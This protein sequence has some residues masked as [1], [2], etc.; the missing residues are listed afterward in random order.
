MGRWPPS[1]LP[2]FVPAD[3]GDVGGVRVRLWWWCG[4][5]WRG[6]VSPLFFSNHAPHLP[7]HDR[8]PLANFLKNADSASM[9][10]HTQNALGQHI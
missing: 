9:H 5:V 6:A 8:T 10:E 2:R 4:K 3:D 1:R 7:R